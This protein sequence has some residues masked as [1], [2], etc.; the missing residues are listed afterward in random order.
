[1]NQLIIRPGAIGDTLLTFP[2]LQLLRERTPNAHITFI[3]N[4]AVLPLALA[5]GVA[6]EVYDYQD[7]RWARLFMAKSE[8]DEI[9]RR[10]ERAVCWL[11]DPEGIV[12]R[13]VCGA[14]VGHVVV[15]PGRPAV[16]EVVHIVEYLAGTV[17]MH[18]KLTE[19]GK[20]TLLRLPS[21]EGNASVRDEDLVVVHPGSGGMQK[22][23]PVERFAA[24]IRALWQRDQP[25]LVLAGPAE[26]SRMEELRGRIGE[27]PCPELLRWLIDAPLLE[28]ARQVAGC[29]VYL[30]N[31][32]GLTHL[33][34]LLLQYPRRIER[35]KEPST[36]PPS[37]VQQDSGYS[38]KK[39]TSSSFVRGVPTIALFG[40][41]DPAIWHPVGPEV[42]V[43]RE[44]LLEGIEVGRVLMALEQNQNSN[45]KN[46]YSMGRR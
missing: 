13:N 20:R 16:G 5:C 3:G 36:V 14:G 32:S 30:G 33:A 15:A 37:T 23:W 26:R 40:P 2:V 24:V 12:E 1:M 35:K 39:Q 21:P 22:C 6:D 44:P 25:V 10:S 7:T 28:V 19:E 9:V 43:I 31:D 4:A 46:R 29:R 45:F 38:R 11:R 8:Q 41:S 34:S 42:T 17:G 27:P 18:W